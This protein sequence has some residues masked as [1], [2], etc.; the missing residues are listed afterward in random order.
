[1]SNYVVWPDSESAVRDVWEQF[2]D[3][4]E[5]HAFASDY[6][7]QYDG[8]PYKVILHI[9]DEYGETIDTVENIIEH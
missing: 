5:A 7:H 8:Y 9:D 3:I 1:M 2:D 6:V 4:D